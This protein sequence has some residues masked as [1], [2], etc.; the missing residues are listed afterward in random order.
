MKFRIC[1]V[2]RG[3]IIGI[4]QFLQPSI[5]DMNA[6]VASLV[7]SL[8]IIIVYDLLFFYCVFHYFTSEFL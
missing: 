5:Q 6:R 8:L 3:I 2:L 4:L 1:D 7:F